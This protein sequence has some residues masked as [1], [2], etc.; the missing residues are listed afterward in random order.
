M[1]AWLQSQIVGLVWLIVIILSFGAAIFAGAV[2][3]AAAN[4]VVGWI[5]GVIVLILLVTVTQPLTDSL[6]RTACE[7]NVNKCD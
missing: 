7:L 6:G 2:V 1:L 3:S 5:A 4:K